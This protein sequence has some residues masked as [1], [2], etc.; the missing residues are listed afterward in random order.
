M[1]L[2][3]RSD[4]EAV[5]YGERHRLDYLVEQTGY[6]L[7]VAAEEWEGLKNYLDAKI[8]DEARALHA[9]DPFRASRYNLSILH[10][11]TGPAR[12]GEQTPA[13]G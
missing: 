6:T 9:A 8:L 1:G 10:R 3:E 7:G 13:A 5:S 2:I 11:R 4:E 12:P